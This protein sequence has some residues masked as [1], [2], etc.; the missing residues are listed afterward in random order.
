MP[1]LICSGYSPVLAMLYSNL[2][3]PSCIS[4]GPYYTNSGFRLPSPTLSLLSKL[5]AAFCISTPVKIA[6]IS[7]CGI[8]GSNYFV[9]FS[10]YSKTSCVSIEC[11]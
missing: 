4:G 10:S 5:S 8:V 2:A 6:F 3:M 7:E 1:C 11:Q 9:Y